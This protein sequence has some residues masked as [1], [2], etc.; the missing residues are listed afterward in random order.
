ML[1]AAGQLAGLAT[2]RMEGSWATISLVLMDK[3]TRR[4]KGIS[5]RG[6]A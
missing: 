5:L 6:F 2:S 3:V 1:Q 4:L